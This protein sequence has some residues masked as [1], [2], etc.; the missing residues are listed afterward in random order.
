MKYL[1]L[2][3]S[4][5]L[6]GCSTAPVVMKFPEAPNALMERC[7]DLDKIPQTKQLSV[8]AETVIKNYS[9]YHNCKLKVDEW[10]NWY[11]S[12]KKIFESVK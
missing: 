3:L 9:K 1:A 7:E 12:N 4:L 6:V 8:T 10:Q 5:T 11:N 2:L